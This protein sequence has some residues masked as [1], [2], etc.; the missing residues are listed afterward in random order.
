MQKADPEIVKALR[1]QKEVVEQEN[2]TA[3]PEEAM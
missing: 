3:T 1:A 2:P